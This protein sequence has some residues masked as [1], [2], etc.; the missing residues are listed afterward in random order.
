MIKLLKPEDKEK[1]TKEERT[2]TLHVGKHWFEWLHISSSKGIETRRTYHI[3]QVL[4][5]EYCQPL[6]LYSAMVYIR[7]EGKI[8]AFS[9]KGKLKNL[10]LADQ[11]LKNG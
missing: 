2:D 8:K 9:D 7:E 1:I 4:K 3:F 10:S 11:T 5:D 6:I